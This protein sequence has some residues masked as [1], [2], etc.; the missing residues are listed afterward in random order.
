[1]AKEAS[2]HHAAAPP[3]RPS[4]WSRRPRPGRP[5]PRS[6]R[7]RPATRRTRRALAA[8][9]EAEGI[10]TRARREADQIVKA[11]RH[12]GGGDHLQRRRRD[13]ASAGRPARRGRPAGQA[14]RRHHRPAGLPPG[15]RRRLRR[16]RVLKL[17][18]PAPGGEAHPGARRTPTPNPCRTWW[19]GSSTRSATMPTGRGG[20]RRLRDRALGGPLAE[21]IDDGPARVRRAK[22]DR[23]PS[24][25]PPRPSTP[26]PPFFVG[27]V[28]LSARCWRTASPTSSCHRFDPAPDH[29]PLFLAAG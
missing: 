29:R 23:R 26:G 1:M 9:R 17:A 24:V 20:G 7:G 5:P 2:D 11:A 28:G 25:S 6:A 27:F 15:R 4:G 21:Q 14:P 10:L 19:R 16:R 12:P 18:L 3:P 22:T 8:Q 13:R